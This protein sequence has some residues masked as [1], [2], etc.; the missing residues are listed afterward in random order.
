MSALW[1]SLNKIDKNCRV[2]R[3]DDKVNEPAEINNTKRTNIKRGRHAQKSTNVTHKL[4]VT[5]SRN[6][7]T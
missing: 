7:V 6:I 4:I 3:L 2:S 5:A 1:C